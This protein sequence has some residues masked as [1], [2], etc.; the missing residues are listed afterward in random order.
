MLRWLLI[1]LGLI[2]ALPL[3]AVGG[4][5][6]AL[7]QGWLNGVIEAR[8][9]AATG[10]EIELDDAPALSL[11]AWALRLTAGPLAVSNA[12]GEQLA[13]IEEV[14]AELALEPLLDLQLVL[15]LIE[16][17]GVD[18]EVVRNENGELNWQPVD[19]P[20][21]PDA[22]PP[23]IPDIRHLVVQDVQVDYRD[24]EQELAL[25]LDELEARWGET[26]PFELA[27][28]GQ[29]G[30]M[31][32]SIQGSGPSRQALASEG[33]EPLSASLDI[34]ATSLA[35]GLEPGTG[36][37]TAQLDAGD[38][39]TDLLAA[40]GLATPTLPPFELALTGERQGDGVLVDAELSLDDTRLRFDGTIGSFDPDAKIEGSL[41]ASGPNPGPVLARFGLPQ[42]DTPPYAVE[43]QFIR[44]GT[45]VAMEELNGTV[46]DSDISGSFGI[47]YGEGLPHVTADLE[48]RLL[49]FDDLFPLLGL[50][51]QTG[52]D[53]TAS[54]AQEQAA[55]RPLD[56]RARVIPDFSIDP[57]IWRGV[58]L[59]IE[60][61]A[62]EVR[63]R[64]L[65][66]DRFDINVV[67]R[68]GWITIDPLDT[69][70]A[71]GRIVL[72]GSF[73]TTQRPPVGRLDVRLTNLS[74]RYLL[75]ELGEASEAAGLVDG[76]IRL[77][78][79]GYSIADLLGTSDGR[80][81]LV[82]SDGSLDAFI[83]EAIGL[84]LM[85][86]L[87]TL[88]V[89]DNATNRV[90]VR[91]AVVNLDVEDGVAT[92]RPILL[93]TAD[94]KLTASGKIDLEAETMDLLIEAHPKDVSLLSG[95]QPIQVEG[96]WLSPTI[97][98]APG[99]VESN[100]FGW[101][102]APVAALFPFVDLGLAEDAP[103]G[104]LLADAKNAAAEAPDE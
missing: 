57:S 31:P 78:G 8:A 69:G 17:Q 29:L 16:V 30:G 91:C 32:A 40:L 24:P 80:I 11:E 84:D 39:F 74:V 93:D 53:E 83:V 50:P 7:Q 102:L 89:P 19:Q 20:S 37:L 77:E 71:D 46:G 35:V 90:P 94:S 81:G 88:I 4:L 85:E 28:S 66:I 15:P 52:P 62:A 44:D 34:A 64:L 18:A 55:A 76:R 61:R 56:E 1:T 45:A 12:D 3:L 6:L 68:D 97:A 95:N 101:L 103:C 38:D 104:Q 49:D 10:Y 58:D 21:E 96:E 72:Y 82:A 100:T 87:I 25:A 42:I 41:A 75:A 54:A 33:G 73:D 67:T 99:G 13:T 70:L 47:D 63:T 79:R 36:V 86:G 65:P 43:G 27:G 22:G 60:L 48:S 26:Q 5:W 23:T 9:S 2:I 59:D 92:S 14:A 51:P 98:P